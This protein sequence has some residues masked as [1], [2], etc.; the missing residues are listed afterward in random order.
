VTFDLTGLPPAPEDV[1]RF[2]SDDS[3]EAYEKAVERLLSSPSYGERWARHWLDLV[4]FA[5]TSG[6]E[7]DYE[8]E[9]ASLYRDYV[10]RALNADVPYDQFVTEHIAGDLL[11]APRRHPVTGINESVIGT[12]FYWLGQGKHSPVD[13][14][15]EECDT[16]DNQL[17][18]LGKTFL[19]LTIACARCHDHKFDPITTEDYYAMTGYLQSSRR[20]HAFID[21]PEPV[22]SL[23]TELKNVQAARSRVVSEALHRELKNGN[24]FAD[25]ILDA[26]DEDAGKDPS[27]PLHVWAV[28][29]GLNEANEFQAQKTQ[30]VRRLSELQLAANADEVFA[31]CTEETLK[32]WSQTGFAF[33]RGPASS[34]FLSSSRDRFELTVPIASN[35]G[36]VSVRL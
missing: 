5:E 4:R 7:F 29:S 14:L 33:S 8:I 31:D 27:H 34:G 22:E 6:H 26:A 13:L 19:G 9:H 30:L 36:S 23:I 21:P 28:L 24:A 35:R 16:I 18:V 11:E 32:G 15:A 20:Q 2:L 17:D 1:Q 25:R 10:V 3:P 12:G